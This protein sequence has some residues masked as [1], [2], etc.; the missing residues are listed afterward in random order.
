MFSIISPHEAWGALGMDCSWV[1]KDI[2]S[3]GPG[4]RC[5]F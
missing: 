4:R 5:T 2:L 3:W 1:M